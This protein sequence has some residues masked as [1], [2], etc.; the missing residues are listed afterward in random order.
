MDN[1]ILAAGDYAIH[2]LDTIISRG[3]RIDFN[4]ALDARLVTEE[5]AIRLARIRWLGSRIRFGCDTH[6]QIAECQRAIDLINSHGF[7]GEYFLYTMIG[8]RNDF[9]EC[10]QRINYWRDKII[11]HRTTHQG[12]ATYAYAQPYR[13]PTNP[14]HIIPQWQK[15][16]AQ[17]CNKRMLYTTIPFHV[18]SPRKGFT[19]QAYLDQ[20]GITPSST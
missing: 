19:C 15:D 6:T 3:Y 1:N 9:P 2:Q 12:R 18:F 4:Q 10:Y 14:H 8:G 20:Y 13:D 7:R 11:E 16:L 5:F 17:W